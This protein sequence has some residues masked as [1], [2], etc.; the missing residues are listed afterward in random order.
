MH[1]DVAEL[2]ISISYG[3]WLRKKE[4]L[5]YERRA[6]FPYNLQIHASIIAQ[7][8]RLL[9][10]YYG[11]LPSNVSPCCDTRAQNIP[12]EDL[13]LRDEGE[14]GYKLCL[15]LKKT[16]RKGKERYLCYA[17][18]RSPRLENLQIITKQA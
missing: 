12:C 2:N 11:C 10:L 17:L 9:Y 16:T 18:S 3:L 14:M 1:C 13:R 8:F 5:E 6:K 4:K 7:W 15:A